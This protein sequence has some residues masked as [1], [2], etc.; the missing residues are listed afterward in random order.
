MN[1]PRSKPFTNPVRWLGTL[2][3]LLVFLSVSRAEPA[4]G[5]RWLLVF[6]TS[7]T[8][9]KRLPGTEAALKHFIATSADGQIQAGDSVGVWFFDQQLNGQFPTWNWDPA[10]T[11]T[12]SSN[13]CTYLRGLRHRQDSNLGLLQA[14]LNRVVANSQ[15]LTIVIFSDGQSQI[16]GTPYDEGIN[17]T[18]R[19]TQAERKK[20]QQPFVVVMRTQFGQYIG[21]TLNFPPGSIML[22]PFPALPPPPPPVVPPPAPAKV[23]SPPVAVPALVI[24]GTQVGTNLNA[25][26]PAPTNHIRVSPPTNEI[27]NLQAT[28]QTSATPAP[29]V[30]VTNQVVA[31]VAPAIAGTNPVITVSNPVAPVVA[32]SPTNVPPP[33][34]KPVAAVAISASNLVAATVPNQPDADTKPMIYLGIAM[35]AAAGLLVVILLVR[36][37]HRAHSSLITSSMQDDPRRK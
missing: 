37:G 17:Q 8:M 4:G 16:I 32:A 2:L 13:L 28:N 34:E 27:L 5:G 12:T 22:P 35:L 25:P 20:S 10:L 7:S 14:P 33:A 24:I 15:R 18:F 19:D 36:P 31:Q 9:K 21:C 30:V 29:V 1:L 26:I 11:G 6:D 23:V 3:T